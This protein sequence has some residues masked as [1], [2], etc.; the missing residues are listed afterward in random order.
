MPL[1]GLVPL[2]FL[3]YLKIALPKGH[4]GSAGSGHGHCGKSV[5]EGVSGPLRRLRARTISRKTG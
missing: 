3:A 4:P 2:G 1:D 5:S